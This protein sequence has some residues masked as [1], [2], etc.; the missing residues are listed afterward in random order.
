MARPAS[1]GVPPERAAT[2]S[3]LGFIPDYKVI[4]ERSMTRK[5][6]LPVIEGKE[7]YSTPTVSPHP[8]RCRHRGPGGRCPDNG[9]SVLFLGSCRQRRHAGIVAGA[10]GICEIVGDGRGSRRVNQR[11]DDLELLAGIAVAT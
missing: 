9:D 7:L 5:L 1:W 4:S 11:D 10:V 6:R 3:P 8:V 2:P